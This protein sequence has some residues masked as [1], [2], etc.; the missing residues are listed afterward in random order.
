MVDHLIYGY[1][2]TCALLFYTDVL[3]QVL[4]I[5]LHLNGLLILKLDLNGFLYLNSGALVLEF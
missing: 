4:N 3:S 2:L 5:T 1:K